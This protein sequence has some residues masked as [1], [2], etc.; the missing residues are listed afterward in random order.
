MRT[1]DENPKRR[2]IGHF[3]FEI[4]LDGTE[5]RERERE[6]DRKATWDKPMIRRSYLM[7]ERED[8]RQITGYNQRL[9]TGREQAEKIAKVSISAVTSECTQVTRLL[10]C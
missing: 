3:K 5:F 9:R 6:R 7:P 8:C 2:M 1:L 10:D 4:H